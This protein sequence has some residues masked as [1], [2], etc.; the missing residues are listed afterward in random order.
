MMKTIHKSIIFLLMYALALN[1]ISVVLAD[2]ASGLLSNVATKQCEMEGKA[3]KGTKNMDDSSSSMKMADKSDCKCQKD[4]Q[5]GACGISC[6]DCGHGF[7]AI[8]T[9]KANTNQNN[10]ELIH[11]FSSIRHQQP[12]LV[13]YRPPKLLNS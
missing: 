11:N 5:Q 3:H 10:S 4:C 2:Q 12:L 9:F 8:I 7:V 13:H 6:S 1:P